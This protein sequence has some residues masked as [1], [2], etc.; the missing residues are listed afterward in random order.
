LIHA[1]WR[2]SDVATYEGILIASGTRD[3]QIVISGVVDY[4]NDN[5]HRLK[6]E[7]GASDLSREDT[8]K[9]LLQEVRANITLPATPDVVKPNGLAPGPGVMGSGGPQ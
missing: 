2:S 4:L 6:R 5:A 3:M 7:I 1:V 8:R 9:I